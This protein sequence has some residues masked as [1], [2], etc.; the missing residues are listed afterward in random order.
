MESSHDR[1]QGPLYQPLAT[2]SS[3]RL[4]SLEAGEFDDQIFGRLVEFM[5]EN[6]NS[7][8]DYEALSYVWGSSEQMH[9]IRI[10]DREV[11][12]R[13]NLYNAL[14]RLRYPDKVR[15]IWVDALSISQVDLAEKAQ[16]VAMISS[17]FRGAFRIV[18]WVGEHADFSEYIFNDASW[19]T[20]Y[21]DTQFSNSY[22]A[23][24]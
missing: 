9:T 2:D 1:A 4:F 7:D 19:E 8:A 6:C 5:V 15:T 14:R 20:F 23:S 18:A 10:D 17:I 16:Q 13:D 3:I 22:D 12:I 11:A 21:Q 24:A